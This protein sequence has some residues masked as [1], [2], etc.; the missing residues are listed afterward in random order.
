LEEFAESRPL[1]KDDPEKYMGMNPMEACDELGIT[2]AQLVGLVCAE[3]DIFPNPRHRLIKKDAFQSSS[4]GAPPNRKPVFARPAPAF[5]LYG[6]KSPGGVTLGKK[7]GQNVDNYE[8]SA[9]RPYTLLSTSTSLFFNTNNTNNTIATSPYHRS[10]ATTVA[11][12]SLNSWLHCLSFLPFKI[13]FL[14]SLAFN[15][16]IHKQH[17]NHNPSHLPRILEA[18]SELFCIFISHCES[19]SEVPLIP[20]CLPLARQLPFFASSPLSPMPVTRNL[21]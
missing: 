1:F 10:L 4:R 3:D 12:A 15:N 13:S 7:I 21:L 20:T 6:P 9:T 19:R 8:V 5:N 18:K 11:A 2:L 16:F 17:H 14:F